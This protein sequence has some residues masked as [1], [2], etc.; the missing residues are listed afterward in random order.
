MATTVLDVGLSGWAASTDNPDVKDSRNLPREVLF[1]QAT[2]PNKFA[3]TALD[4]RK[5]AYTKSPSG[6]DQLWV[7]DPITMRVWLNNE[8]AM[9]FVPEWPASIS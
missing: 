6:A 1:L 2:N 4:G 5:F 3:V 8:W 7:A 9:G